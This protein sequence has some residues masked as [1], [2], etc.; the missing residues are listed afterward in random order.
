[1][2]H[3]RVEHWDVNN[4]DIHGDFFEQATGNANITMKMFHDSHN[5]DPHVKLFLND[6]GI[7]ENT[8]TMVNT[9]IQYT[10]DIAICGI[11]DIL[12]MNIVKKKQKQKKTQNNDEFKTDRSHNMSLYLTYIHAILI[13]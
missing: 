1:M 13:G 7:M 5:V 2:S 11:Y 4:E 6:Y 8:A 9:Y 10:L 3:S 12:L